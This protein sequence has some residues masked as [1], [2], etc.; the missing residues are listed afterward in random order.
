MSLSKLSHSDVEML[1]EQW[2]N[3]LSLLCVTFSKY[4]NADER[5]VALSMMAR[6]WSIS[7]AAWFLRTSSHTG[8]STPLDFLR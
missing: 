6:N 3:E 5:K 2:R 8:T 7:F 1:V 4:S